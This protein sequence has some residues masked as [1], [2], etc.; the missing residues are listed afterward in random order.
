MVS[1]KFDV[2]AGGPW[3][4]WTTWDQHGRA[5]EEVTLDTMSVTSIHSRYDGVTRIITTTSV[6]LVHESIGTVTSWVIAARRGV[7]EPSL[8]FGEA[9]E[10]EEVLGD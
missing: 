8:I 1:V 10:G 2:L 7:S 3:L 5:V 4:A 6:L 9:P